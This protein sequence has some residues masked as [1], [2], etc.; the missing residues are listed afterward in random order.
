MPQRPGIPQF[1]GRVPVIGQRQQQTEDQ[2]KAQAAAQI[3]QA[4][5][6]LSQMIYV[7]FVTAEWA[8][9][10]YDPNKMRD[11]AKESMTAARCYFEGVGALTVEEETSHD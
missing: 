11:M 2:A 1:G 6:Q 3:Q 8:I 5:N 9:P 4:V 10:P 7:R